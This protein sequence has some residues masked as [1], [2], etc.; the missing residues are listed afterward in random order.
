MLG[1]SLEEVITPGASLEVVM[2]A[3]ARFP[4]GGGCLLGCGLWEGA[5][6]VG[7]RRR[8]PQTARPVRLHRHQRWCR[9][10]GCYHCGGHFVTCSIDI[11]VRS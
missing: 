2:L 6:G 9:L 10:P 5:G 1:A 11:D 8:S 3:V 4:A 7:L